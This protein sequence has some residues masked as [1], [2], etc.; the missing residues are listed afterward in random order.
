PLH[1]AGDAFDV[2]FEGHLMATV[3]DGLHDFTGADLSAADLD[4]VPLTGIRWSP[5]T[6]WPAGWAGHVAER[7]AEREPG[8]YVIRAGSRVRVAT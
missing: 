6:R 5:A 3:A 2:R 4:D 1:L 7:S 8:V